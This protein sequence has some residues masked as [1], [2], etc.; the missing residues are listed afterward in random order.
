MLVLNPLLQRIFRTMTG[1]GFESYLQSLPSLTGLC[2]SS[3]DIKHLFVASQSL[4]L[5]NMT[6]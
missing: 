5:P 6:G 4:G 2:A 1:K 3:Y